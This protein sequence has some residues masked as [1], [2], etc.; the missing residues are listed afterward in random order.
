MFNL[1]HIKMV[2]N[3]QIAVQY[4][5]YHIQF[6]NVSSETLLHWQLK[7][8]FMNR[9]LIIDQKWHT[10][11]KKYIYSIKVLYYYNI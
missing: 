5:C 1:I 2:I 8:A 9:V 3:F 11:Y 6:A 10:T 7:R 4:S